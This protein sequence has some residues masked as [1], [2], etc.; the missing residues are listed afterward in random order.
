[1]LKDPGLP[2]RQLVVHD[3]DARRRPC[4]L[5]NRAALVPG[6]DSTFEQ[7]PIHAFNGDT[8]GLGFYFG[9][10]L[11]GILDLTLDVGGRDRGL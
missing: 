10:P 11:Q 3:A 4:G 8:D 2:D 7:Y 5:F 6:I 9:M 1:M